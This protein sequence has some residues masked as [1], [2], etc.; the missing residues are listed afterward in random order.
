M[1]FGLGKSEID[2][3]VKDLQKTPFSL[4]MDGGMKGGKHRINYILL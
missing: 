2:T 4:S 1:K 3:T